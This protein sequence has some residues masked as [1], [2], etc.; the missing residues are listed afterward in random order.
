GSMGSVFYIHRVSKLLDEMVRDL[1]LTVTLS[2]A[3]TDVKLAPQ[4]ENLKAM[5]TALGV[6]V[7]VGQQGTATIVVFSPK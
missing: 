5:A 6:R 7:E 3:K 2:D 1:G 4:V